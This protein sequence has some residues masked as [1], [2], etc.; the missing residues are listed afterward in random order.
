MTP[1]Q[2]VQTLQLVDSLFPVGS[3]AYSDGMETAA[4][5]AKNSAAFLAGWL[6]HYLNCVFAPCDGLAL[7]K[8]MRAAAREDWDA[9][10]TVDEELTALKPAA[11]VRAGSKSIGKGLLKMYE[12]IAPDDRLRRLTA[13]LPDSNA[14]VAYAVVF[15]HRTLAPRDA[16]VAFGYTRLAG[17]V[18]AA[19]RLTAMGQQQGQAILTDALNRLPLVVERVLRSEAE[20][21]RSFGPLLDVQQMNHRYVYSRLF[22]S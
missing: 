10:R 7:L 9:I 13:T 3:F 16:L 22:R 11:A 14:A 18:S 8:C 15:A 6:D 5:D 19:L 1:E 4:A 21:L 20:P 12:S 17:M 2:F